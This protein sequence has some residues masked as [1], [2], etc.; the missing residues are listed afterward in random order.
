MKQYTKKDPEYR[1]QII[2]LLILY[3]GFHLC[4]E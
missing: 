4:Q 1:A 2:S 3:E